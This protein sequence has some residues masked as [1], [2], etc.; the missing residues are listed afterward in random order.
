MLV[1][2]SHVK[3]GFSDKLRV[4]TFF[5]ALTKL[6]KSNFSLYVYEKK[7]FQCPFRFVDFCEVKNF[8]LK[9]IKYISKNINDNKIIMN[10][11]NSEI[12]INN[13][14]QH[15]LF[16]NISNYK[17]LE[18]WKLSY[19]DIIPNINLN[20]KIKKINLPKKFVSIHIRSTDRIINFNR[21]FLDLQLKDMFFSFQLKKF[22]KNLNYLIKKNTDIKS[23]YIASDEED[24]K[25]KIIKSLKKNGYKVYYNECKYNK[26]KFRKT[27]G[28]DFLVDLF[29]LSGS[30]IIFTTVGGGVPYTAQLLS[31]KKTRIINW[32]NQINFHIFL[33][34]LVYIIYYLKRLKFRL[35][36]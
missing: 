35:L 11:Y 36:N 28:E 3:S 20:K 10:S 21:I 8:S 31:T 14:K 19:R 13:C 26:N 34:I 15:N 6:L 23:I 29:C 9:K 4:I 16:N 17:L 2:L 32:V 27:S 25:K 1:D 5:I 33:R 7:N 12:N 30:E 18:E 24:F 22:E